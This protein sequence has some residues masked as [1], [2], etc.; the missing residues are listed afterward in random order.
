MSEPTEY[1]E[2]LYEGGL[3]TLSQDERRTREAFY[4]AGLYDLDE[5]TSTLSIEILAWTATL[6]EVVTLLCEK[7]L[8]FEHKRQEQ[9]DAIPEAGLCEASMAFFQ[10]PE[11]NHPWEAMWE[12]SQRLDPATW[13]QEVFDEKKEVKK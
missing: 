3:K 10:R 5:A 6:G 9:A 4:Q 12:L 7:Y 13:A 1:P 8:R 2:W 11:I